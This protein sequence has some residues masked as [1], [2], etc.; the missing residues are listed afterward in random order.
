MMRETYGVEPAPKILDTLRISHL[1]DTNMSHALKDWSESIYGNTASYYES[2]VEEYR[3]RYKI[4]D[5]S[6]IPPEIMD[7]YATNDVVLTKSL[8][9]RFAEKVR[10]DNPSLFDMEMKLIPVIYDLSLIH[11]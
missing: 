6:R 8:A 4:K 2:L 9:E 11:I 1:Y 5:Y 3:S 10:N 7:S